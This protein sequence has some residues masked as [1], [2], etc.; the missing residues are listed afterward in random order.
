[1][2]SNIPLPNGYIWSTINLDDDKELD[3]VY[4]FLA[5]HYVENGKFR[6]NYSKEFLLWA[7]KPPGYIKDWHVGVRGINGRLY[8]LITGIPVHV[9]IEN[10][11]MKM[12][13]INFLCVHHGLRLKRLAPVLIKE[14]TRRANLLN[15]W[16]AVYTAGVKLSNSI[17]I[18]QYWHRPLQPKKLLEIG[19]TNLKPRMTLS[20]TIKLY[21][22]PETQKLS[23][24]RLMTVED[25]PQ[26]CK[27]L[28]SYLKSKTKL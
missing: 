15:I 26:V 25:I 28:N 4:K 16:Q 19:F 7:L 18:S 3:E 23:G 14:I 21:K 8:G 10:N 13:E 9:H 12:A 2:E 17:T 11:D 1:M 20:R 27:L 6:F 22:L 5:R 24:I